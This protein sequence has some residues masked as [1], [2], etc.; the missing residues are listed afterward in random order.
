MTPIRRVCH[1]GLIL[2]LAVGSALAA[3]SQVQSST[4]QSVAEN[5][6]EEEKYYADAHPYL[7]LPLSKLKKTVDLLGGLKPAPDQEQLSAILAKLAAKTDEALP[8]IPNLLADEAVTETQRAYFQGATPHCIAGCLDPAP[9]LQRDLKFNYIILAHPAQS[10]VVLLEEYRTDRDGKPV[11]AADAPHFQG[12]ASLW[13]FFS[14]SDQVELR[15]HY[16]G[17]QKTDGHAAF[18]IGFAQ[19]PGSIEY[20]AMIVTSKGTIPMLL[21]G[22]VWIDQAD[23][24]IV[25]LHADLLAPQPDFNYLK[26]TF[27]IQFGPARISALSLDLWLPRAVD[28]ETEAEGQLWKEQHRYTKYRLY[29]TKSKIILGPTN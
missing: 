20:P 3:H 7:D 28:V 8:K 22:V 21:Q 1:S 2:S 27:D 23:F 4:H 24:R 19:I 15:F 18:V 11:E 12:F 17:Q 10:R 14:S 29:Q 9:G 13:A 16:L 6:A 25:R 5:K 26:Q